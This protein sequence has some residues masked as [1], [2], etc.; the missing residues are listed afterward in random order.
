MKLLRVI[1]NL[2][3]FDRTN[4]KALALC[5][6]AAAVFWIFNALNKN[7][8]TNLS[9][10]LSVEYDETRFA[11]AESIPPKLTVNV[12]GNGWE[13]LRKYLG[14]KVP[15]ISLP[16]E[17]PADVHRIAGAALAPQIVSQLGV[18]QLNYVV[19][20]TLRIA[21]E[22][23][24]ARKLRLVASLDKVTFKKG[25][26]RISPVTILPDSILLEGPKSYIKSLPDSIVLQVQANR[27]SSN[28]NENLEI[29]LEHG[30]F[31]SRNPPV[32]EVTFEVGPIAEVS[33]RLALSVS[34]TG[35]LV[36]EADSI[37]ITFLI[38][39]R[40]RE[41]FSADKNGLTASLPPIALL[42]GD[43]ILVK[44]IIKGLPA[45]ASILQV[46]SLLV[47]RTQ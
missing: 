42:K 16:L 38:P 1:S 4:W 35:G 3:R 45:Y 18:L 27:V 24:I 5:L 20:D 15:V 9:L 11:A 41:Q 31:I 30:D 12:N 40:S 6:L 14:Q 23:K 46:D 29:Q 21:I 43:T 39:E 8:S 34:K 33:E 13:L 25:M 37:L 26:G 17:R 36:A 28:Y 7:Y 2:L 47:R 32:A 22:Q 44:P 10:P 19:L